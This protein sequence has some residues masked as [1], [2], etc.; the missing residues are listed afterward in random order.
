MYSAFSFC[1]DQTKKETFGCLV[2]AMRRGNKLTSYYSTWLRSARENQYWCYESS[3]FKS[4]WK[5]ICCCLVQSQSLMI[6]HVRYGR[7]QHGFE[8]HTFVAHASLFNMTLS[9]ADHFRRRHNCW[10]YSTADKPSDS[11]TISSSGPGAATA[12]F[13]E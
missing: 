2:M 1:I 5:I 7:Q 6:Q 3:L 11:D 10:I 9:S 8:K 4:K 13:G 12:S